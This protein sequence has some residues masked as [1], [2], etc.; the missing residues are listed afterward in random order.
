MYC[1]LIFVNSL[2]NNSL[3]DLHR[4]RYA[5]RNSLAK[6]HHDD[7]YTFPYRKP[8]A[9]DRLIICQTK[10]KIR[11]VQIQCICRR[12]NKCKFKTEIIYGMSRKHCG[13]RRKML[14][15][16][17][18]FFFPQGFFRRVVKSRD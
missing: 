13:K 15:T 7:N 10:K 11:L 6:R 5:L 3:S 18:F 2:S 9:A 14:V 16:S 17:I 12:Q 8:F 4:K 1:N